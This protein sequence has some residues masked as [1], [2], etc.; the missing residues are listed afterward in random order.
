ME[1]ALLVYVLNLL[2]NIDHFFGGFVGGLFFI[3]I[4]SSVFGAIAFSD[5][6]NDW[7]EIRDFLWKYFLWPKVL[8]MSLVICLFIPDEKTMQFMAGAYLVQTVYEA[9]FTQKAG[10]LAGEAVI[11]QLEVWAADNEKVKELLD[12]VDAQ[13]LVK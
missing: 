7:E 8:V 13:K 9:D 4:I 12:Q 11:N 3:A 10:K 1:L 2:L 6:R 5:S